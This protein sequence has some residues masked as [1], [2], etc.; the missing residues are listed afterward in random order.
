ME[1]MLFCWLILFS[2]RLPPFPLSFPPTCCL[3]LL[4]TLYESTE[5]ASRRTRTL[6]ASFPPLTPSPPIPST[7]LLPLPFLVLS[8]P[9]GR[10]SSHPPRESP[11]LLPCLPPSPVRVPPLSLPSH[12]ILVQP[13]G[14][15]S[16]LVTEDSTRLYKLQ[17]PG[18]IALSRHR[19]HHRLM[20]ARS[21]GSSWPGG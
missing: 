16:A 5:P 18:G 12:P 2:T 3:L 8:L 19:P 17:Q 4:P 14:T 11:Y 13:P 10:S 20:L 1:A 21:D 7:R 6:T 15:P 9:Q